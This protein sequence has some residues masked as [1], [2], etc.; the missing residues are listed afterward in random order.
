MHRYVIGIDPSGNYFEGKGTTGWCVLDNTHDK[1]VKINS[2]SAKLFDTQSEYW[3]EHLHLI[4][5]LRQKYKD[6]VVVVEAYLLYANESKSQINSEMETPQLI[7]VLKMFCYINDIPIHFHKA[8]TVKKR[9]ADDILA[10][11]QYIYNQK[12]HWY[13]NANKYAL[14][15]HERDAIRHAVHYNT[16]ENK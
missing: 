2:I 16:F 7:G 1:V 11:E 9:W 3:Y 10:H 4:D 12:G 8:A 14:C 15:D 13:C 5:R 6:I